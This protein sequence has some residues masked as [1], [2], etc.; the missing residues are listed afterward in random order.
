[1][2]MIFIDIYLKTLLIMIIG[3]GTVEVSCFK[4]LYIIS[5]NDKGHLYKY[6]NGELTHENSK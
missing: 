6:K 2:M 5:T 1:M 3:V 4:G